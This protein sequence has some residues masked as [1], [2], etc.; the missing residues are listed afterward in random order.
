M[1]DRMQRLS[2]DDLTR[3]HDVSMKILRSTGVDFNHDRIAGLFKSRGFKTDGP[4]SILKKP[5]STMPC[6]P[7]FPPLRCMPEIRHA[8]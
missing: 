4:G 7:P 5:I 6:P 3:I 8:M 2:F 1:I